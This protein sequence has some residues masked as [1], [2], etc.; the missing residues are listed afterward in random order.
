MKITIQKITK[1]SVEVDIQLP[2]FR[3][4]GNS[5]YKF[6]EKDGLKYDTITHHIDGA[7]TYSQGYAHSPESILFPETT[8]EHYSTELEKFV[9]SVEKD[10]ESLFTQDEIKI[11]SH[12]ELER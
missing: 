6:Y 3:K 10:Q 8:I 7:Y 9:Q 5:L 4:E 11:I 12:S 2:A 1:E